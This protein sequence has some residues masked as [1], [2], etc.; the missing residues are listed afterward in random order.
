MFQSQYL[1]ESI[2]NTLVTE[3]TKDA[4]MPHAQVM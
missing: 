2:S 3:V 1:L 4:H